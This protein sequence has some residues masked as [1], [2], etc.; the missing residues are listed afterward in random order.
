MTLWEMQ[1]VVFTILRM[2]N[3]YNLESRF[4]DTKVDIGMENTSRLIT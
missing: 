4:Q 2:V 1:C 3:I